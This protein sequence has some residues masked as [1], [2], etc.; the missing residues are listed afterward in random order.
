MNKVPRS[1]KLGTFQ[2]RT[3]KIDEKSSKIYYL[4]LKRILSRLFMIS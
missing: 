3:A 4:Y 1:D 2:G